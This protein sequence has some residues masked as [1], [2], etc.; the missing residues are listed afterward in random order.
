MTSHYTV[1]KLDTLAIT[2]SN[3]S[4]IPILTAL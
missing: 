3:D 4:L 1:G 2:D